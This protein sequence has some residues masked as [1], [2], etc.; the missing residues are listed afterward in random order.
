MPKNECKLFFARINNRKVIIESPYIQDKTMKLKRR[1]FLR[2]AVMTAAGAA[3]DCLPLPVYA[4]KRGFYSPVR[5]V[6]GS[7]AAANT[8]KA[9]DMLGGMEKFVKPGQKVF[10]KPNCISTNQPESAV[11][12]NPAVVAEIVR[13]CR[14]AGASEILYMGHDQSRVW[15]SNGIGNAFY[16]YGGK[17]VDA[18]SREQYLPVKLPRGL[19]LRETM[20]VKELLEADVFINIPIAKHHAGTQLTFCLKNYMGLVWDRLIMHRTDIHQAIADLA[21]ARPADLAVIDATRMLLT[22]GPSGPGT[23]RVENTIIA[24]PD[25]LAADAVTA[26]LFKVE[27]G[28]VRHIKAAYDLGLGEIDERE[29]QV[30][31]LVLE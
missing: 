31:R 11:N 29:M 21:T 7:D 26:S 1:E 28:S 17:I 14:K 15:E 16:A 2:G 5:I 9:I 24:S 23:V 25:M 10:I 30:E 6:I 13:L 22:N 27:P 19:I 8:R 20:M 4:I 18:N 3:L 12:T